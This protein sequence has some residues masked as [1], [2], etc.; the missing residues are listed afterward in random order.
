MQNTN[1][2]STFRQNPSSY[3]RGTVTTL[4]PAQSVTNPARSASAVTATT[5]RRY[6]H[7]THFAQTPDEV[8]HAQAR[9]GLR[10][11]E[12]AVQQ[13]GIHLAHHIRGVVLLDE[14]LGLCLG[15]P[16]EELGEGIAVIPAAGRE[17]SLAV[18][19]EKHVVAQ[20]SAVEQLQTRQ[21]TNATQYL[22]TTL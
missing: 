15:G 1:S 13:N 7:H 20:S 10:V 2:C 14:P 5:R 22:G 17:V 18:A 11:E 4:A 21:L 3:S 19:T 16:G 9:H 6:F 8:L 12:D